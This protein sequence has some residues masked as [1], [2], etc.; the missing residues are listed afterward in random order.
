MQKVRKND[1]QMQIRARRVPGK[2]WGELTFST[3]VSTS[4][5]H[6]LSPLSSSQPYETRV[7]ILILDIR[8]IKLK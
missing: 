7:I 6:S 3:A 5:L 2:G 8:K 4:Q 1:E